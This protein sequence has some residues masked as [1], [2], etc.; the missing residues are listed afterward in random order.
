MKAFGRHSRSVFGGGL[1]DRRVLRGGRC[2]T[3][4]NDRNFYPSEKQN[5]HARIP[6]I[7]H[8]GGCT[9]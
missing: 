2:A 8:I 7:I 1:D 3:V 9:L 6:A 5:R 4:E